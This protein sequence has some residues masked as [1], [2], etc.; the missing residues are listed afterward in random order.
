MKAVS[1]LE[2]VRV[3]TRYKLSAMWVSVMFCYIYAD[4]F[5]LYLP[6][7]L[8]GMLAGRMDP[9]GPVTQGVLVGTAV[10]LALPSLMILLSVA[11]PPRVCRWLNIVVAIVY[12]VIQLLVVSGSSWVFYVGFGI[13]ETVLTAL[14]IWTAWTWPRVASHESKVM[15]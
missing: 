7:K 8:Q 10:M 9:L 11:L 3:P 5:E 15:Q 6:G 13:V 2:D 1:A 14:V 4:Y 12:T